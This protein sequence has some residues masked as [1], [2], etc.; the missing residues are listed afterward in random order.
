MGLRPRCAQGSPRSNASFID[1]PPLPISFPN[2]LPGASQDHLPNI[3]TSRPLGKG[4][5][6]GEA[7]S[8]HPVLFKDL[9]LLWNSVE[10]RSKSPEWRV[11]LT[12]LTPLQFGCIAFGESVWGYDTDKHSLFWRQPQG[13]I[14]P[15]KW[16]WLRFQL[17][18]FQLKLPFWVRQQQHVGPSVLAAA[19]SGHEVLHAPILALFLVSLVPWP[20]ADT[21]INSFPFQQS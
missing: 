12:F 5:L 15:Q 16:P 7:L 2:F 13:C 11:I 10:V 8:M 17:K 4:L 6:R 14:H 21:P 3:L 1:S 19:S 9:T 20:F 18:R